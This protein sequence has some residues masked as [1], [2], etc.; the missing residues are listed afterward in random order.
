MRLNL[1]NSK[2]KGEDGKTMGTEK[3]YWIDAYQREFSA[4]VDRVYEANGIILSRTCFCP[5]SGGQL[6]DTGNLINRDEDSIVTVVG[7]EELDNGDIVHK[8]EHSVSWEKGEEINGEI[9]WVS[10]YS[11]MKTHTAQ[12]LLSAY[13]KQIAGVETD[14][15]TLDEYSI[16]IKL[17][18]E[19]SIQQME[20]ILGS[21]LHSISVDSK[22]VRS[23]VITNP[24]LAKRLFKGEEWRGIIPEKTPIRIVEIDTLDFNPCGGVHLRN[25]NEIGPVFLQRFHGEEIEIILGE[26]TPKQI[27]EQMVRMCVLAETLDTNV[28]RLP[29]VLQS[30]NSQ[31]IKCQEERTL[32]IE[33]FLDGLTERTTSLDPDV[34]LLSVRAPFVGAKEFSKMIGPRIEDNVVAICAIQGSAAVVSKHKRIKANDIINE[35]LKQKEGRGGG[36]PGYAVC[37][38]SEEPDKILN[39]LKNIVEKYNARSFEH[40]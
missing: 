38:T 14:K 28:T 18:S 34:N 1:R 23:H 24:D 8:L 30:R 29:T 15:A 27:A 11:R 39:V 32:A 12:H 3:L 10:R 22:E 36:N 2:E 37:S 13:A 9:E 26:D 6:E 25:T 7:I 33:S 20:G 19:L 40:I 35:F 5:R 21:F 17:S 4:V 16:K 31:L